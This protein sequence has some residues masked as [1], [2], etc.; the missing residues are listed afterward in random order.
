MKMKMLTLILVMLLI[1]RTTISDNKF[2]HSLQL[3][4]GLGYAEFLL[5]VFRSPFAVSLNFLLTE[6]SLFETS[7]NEWKIASRF[8]VGTSAQRCKTTRVISSK[9]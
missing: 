1:S 5:T 8:A 6:F 3:N 9:Y 7:L 4:Y 2:H